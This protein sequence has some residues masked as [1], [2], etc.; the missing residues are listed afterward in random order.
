MAVIEGVEVNEGPAGYTYRAQ[1]LGLEGSPPELWYNVPSRF[2][3]MLTDRADPVIV[4]LLI[5]AM[6]S[7]QDIVIRTTS[8]SELLAKLPQLQGLLVGILPCLQVIEVVA[9]DP[10]P[11]VAVPSGVGAGFSAGI[12]SYCVLA[13]HYVSHL[14]YNNVGSH[15]SGSQGRRLF[16]QRYERIS[17]AAREFGTPLVQVDSNL[18]EFYPAFSFLGSH[19]L[20]NASVA[21]LLSHGVGEFLY[22]SAYADSDTHLGP[23][24]SLA[25][26]DPW[27]LP[28]LSTSGLS[29][30][31]VGGEYT[32]LEK[33]ARVANEV[34]S[35]RH[36]LDVCVTPTREGTNCSR[37]WKCRRTMA[38]LDLISHLDFYAD[39]FN[40]R[41][42]RIDRLW[43]LAEIASSDYPME[44]EVAALAASQGQTPPAWATRTLPLVRRTERVARR[45]SRGIR[46]RLGTSL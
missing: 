43:Y 40:L 5:P 29:L 35:S 23:S 30:R 42:W 11:S 18:D 13:D 14:L 22:A 8:S 19:T 31:S 7:G 24:A 4:G 44:A 15:G 34:S 6:R 39:V 38:T 10:Q 26:S 12:D 9:D 46:R 20:R 33:V 28:L 27:T 21:H 17:F 32:R 16:E 37:C 3:H 36:H 45:L 25:A 1:V 41:R 2:G